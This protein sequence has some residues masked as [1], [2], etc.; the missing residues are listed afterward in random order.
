MKTMTIIFINGLEVG[1]EFKNLTL[2]CFVGET[3]FR[4]VRDTSYL[5]FIGRRIEDVDKDYKLIIIQLA[6]IERIDID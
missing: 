4:Q 5:T 3:V 6:R 2:N 1:Y